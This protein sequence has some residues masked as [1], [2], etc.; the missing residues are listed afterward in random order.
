VK[1]AGG[2][3]RT[4]AAVERISVNEGRVSGVVLA[5]GE[6]IRLV[7]AIAGGSR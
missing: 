2:T 6:T 4:G 3:L 1:R 7:A 5:G